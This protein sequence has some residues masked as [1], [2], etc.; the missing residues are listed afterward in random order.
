MYSAKSMKDALHDA[1][2]LRNSS[3]DSKFS[4]YQETSE[5]TRQFY[6][7]LLPLLIEKDGMPLFNSLAAMYKEIVQ[8][9]TQELSHLY[10]KHV[11]QH[12]SET[13]IST[14][15]NYNRELYTSFK[16]ILLAAK[17]ALLSEKEAEY[18]DDLPGFIR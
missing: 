4:I 6:K 14:I 2:L 15:I 16:S 3:N 18:F 1:E 7:K 17:D 11:L 9:Y 8:S 10:K 13:E 12:F 5:K